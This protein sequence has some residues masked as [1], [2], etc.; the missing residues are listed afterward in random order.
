MAS[1]LIITCMKNE[2]PFILEW[3][4][5]HLA[6]GFDHF[7]VFTN[8]CEDNTVEILDALADY[9]IVTRMENPYQ[10]MGSGYNPQKGALKFA[11]SLELTQNCDWV[12]V[13]DVDEFVNIHVG[14]GD[15][16]SL[17]AALPEAEIISMQW[18]LF[19]HGFR[20]KYEDVLL[21]EQHTLCAPMFCPSPLQAWGMKTLFRTK[22]PG[23]AG[24]YGKIGVHRPLKK[25]VDGPIPWV[26]GSGLPVHSD[27]Y[28]GGWRFGIRD[29]GYDMVTLNHYAVRSAESFLV[30]RDRGRVNHVDRDQGLAYWLRMNF[31]M[32]EDRS[33]LRRVPETKNALE[34]LLALPKIKKLHAA[35]VKAHKKK[36]TE[37]KK[38]PDMKNFLAEI[39]S[40]KMNLISKHLN[41]LNR[42]H[43]NDGPSGIPEELF[44]SLERIPE[45]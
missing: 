44:S 15:L 42:K 10:E 35:A 43:F 11:E 37:L 34:D 25:M 19:G 27:H 17:F 9:G 45:L 21:T 39:T 31:N 38:R 13:S 3:V 32:E 2:G 22:G 24:S 6:V 33:I 30:K 4:A 40:P 8:D 1:N 36:I 16:K 18:R 7:L 41:F 20:T 26:N 14:D 23:V 5:H 29:H 12:L 28:D